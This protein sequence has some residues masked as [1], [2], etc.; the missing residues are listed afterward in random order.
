MPDASG[1]PFGIGYAGYATWLA[2]TRDV[3]AAGGVAV[4]APE[5]AGSYAGLPAARY[6]AAVIA[7]RKMGTPLL[8]T[9]G[10][11]YGYFLAPKHILV[12]DTIHQA[13]VRLAIAEGKVAEVGENIAKGVLLSAALGV[14]V[15]V[16]LITRRR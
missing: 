15:V 4:A 6:P 8:W 2:W 11:Q 1:V 13:A 10:K 9:T 3:A 5:Q 16:Y 12:L 14:A 7:Q